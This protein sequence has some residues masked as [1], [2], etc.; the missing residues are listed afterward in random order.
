MRITLKF[1]LL[2]IGLSCLTSGVFADDDRKADQNKLPHKELAPEQP[3]DEKPE[4]SKIDGKHGLRD[5]M[6]H[7][8]NRGPHTGLPDA[9]SDASFDRLDA[10]KDGSISREEFKAAAARM[11][12]RMQQVREEKGADRPQHGPQ[13]ERD[14][15]P[16]EH[17]GEHEQGVHPPHPQPRFAQH[18]PHNRDAVR[19]AYHQG[20][21]AGLK[22]H[23]RGQHHARRHH[24]SWRHGADRHFQHARFGRQHRAG[25]QGRH[26]LRRGQQWR[27]SER[28]GSQY[29]HFE[30]RGFHAHGPRHFTAHSFRHGHRE[31]RAFQHRRAVTAHR[32]GKGVRRNFEHAA[33]HQE[34]GRHRG[35]WFDHHAAPHAMHHERDRDAGH[36]EH[37][38][39]VHSEEVHKAPRRDEGGHHLPQ[40]FYHDGRGDRSGFGPSHGGPGAMQRP[41]LDRSEMNRDRDH[42]DRQLPATRSDQEKSSKADKSLKDEKGPNAEKKQKQEQS[43][44]K[45]KRDEGERSEQR[46]EDRQGDASPAETPA[47]AVGIM[48]QPPAVPLPQSLAVTTHPVL[49]ADADS[50]R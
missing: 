35:G 8:E 16:A 41:F 39:G 7:Q 1:S 30:Q 19:R 26:G 4:P 14:R 6:R 36:S 50:S 10:N 42:Q 43:D 2:V 46:K 31:A 45:K 12:E 20:F 15:R 49:N 44:Q 48:L 18:G 25:F 47:A 27:Y 37:A 40:G 34:F 28:G 13:F 23:Q 5:Q 11:R 38:R 33:P 17:P 24:I 9:H 3:R 32:D 29:D 21:V 22:F